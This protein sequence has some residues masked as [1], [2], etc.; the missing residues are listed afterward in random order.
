MTDKELCEENGMIRCRNMLEKIVNNTVRS[1][2]YN[3]HSLGVFTPMKNTTR[4]KSE[5]NYE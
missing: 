2:Q 1:I 5:G 3:L 4:F